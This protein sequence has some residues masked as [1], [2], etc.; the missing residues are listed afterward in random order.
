M[1]MMAYTVTALSRDTESND[2]FHVSIETTV[3]SP[4]TMGEI[5]G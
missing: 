5:D 2:L 3:F 1:S 4:E